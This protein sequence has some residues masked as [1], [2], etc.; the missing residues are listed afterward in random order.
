M[1]FQN[2]P[3]SD[4][5]NI[6]LS[7]ILK[8]VKEAW[9]AAHNAEE[10]AENLRTFVNEYFDNLDVQEEINTKINNMVLDGSFE[11]VLLQFVPAIIDTWLAANIDN[12]SSPPLDATL[13]L[14]SAAAQAKATGIEINRLR[15]DLLP[16][17]SYNI[18]NDLWTAANSTMSNVAFA[19]DGKT[20]TVSSPGTA[21][22]LAINNL[23]TPNQALPAALEPGK[24]YPVRY[25]T[26]N[27]N[28]LLSFVFYDTDNTRTELQRASD[29][30]ITIPEGAVRW[31]VRL[32]CASGVNP[33]GT[34]SN[35]GLL[36]SMPLAE[37]VSRFIYGNK[38]QTTHTPAGFTYFN[39]VTAFTSENRLTPADMPPNSYFYSNGNRL[40][41]DFMAEDGSL[42]WVFCVQSKHNLAI[43][44][45]IVFNRATGFASTGY[46]IDGG[47]TTVWS[48]ITDAKQSLKV[49]VIGSSF[50]QDC[51]VYSPW[52]MEEMN[53]RVSVT[54]GNV[55]MSG[56]NIDQYNTWFDST[57]TLNYFK[58]S[59]GASAWSRLSTADSSTGMTLKQCLLNERWDMILI[60]QSARLGADYSS[61]ANTLTYINKMADHVGHNVV[62][63]YLMPQRAIGYSYTYDALTAA[64]RQVYDEY[65]VS[66]IVPAG[67][68]IEKARGTT[69][70]SIGDAGHLCYDSEVGH[71]Q[72]G[73]PAL[74][75]N[76]VTAAVLLQVA[77]LG[78]QGIYGSRINPTAEWVASH[79]IPG[80]NGNS[81]GIV[82]GNKL[83]GQ[84][85]AIAGMKEF[86]D[87]Y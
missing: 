31:T 4:L 71:L 76:Y 7:W 11:D 16:F 33:N 35:I 25:T 3:Y 6:N 20:C 84:R 61:F 22:A 42:Y 74:I 13:T 9:L 50:G 63:G 44:Q 24:R 15:D 49:L 37:V 27:T 59:A 64:A 87:Y 46:T 51:S 65:P 66:F 82:G 54:M 1:P 12:P 18:L 19:W 79:V 86:N 40:S 36:T 85:C 57:Q 73:L 69:L 83:I 41:S 17:N 28:I 75:A 29:S 70:D 30:T 34:V 10:V 48:G 77:G 21:S 2:W 32:Y 78:M 81:T 39:G 62:F 55:Y 60:N 53:D 72:E 45:Y 26:S 58:R 68:A 43:R 67:A 23:I 47:V 80:T 14:A 56:G 8:R 38:D 5:G 52:I